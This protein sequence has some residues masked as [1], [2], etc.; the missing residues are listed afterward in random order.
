MSMTKTSKVVY[1][2]PISSFSKPITKLTFKIQKNPQGTVALNLWLKI[3]IEMREG[4]Y[5]Q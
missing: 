2:A 1:A 3:I 5:N 4:V